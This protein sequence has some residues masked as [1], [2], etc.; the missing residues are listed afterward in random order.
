MHFSNAHC[1]AFC[2]LL[3]KTK[4]FILNLKPS[5]ELRISKQFLD[6]FHQML[7]DIIFLKTVFF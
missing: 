4:T 7:D 2:G 5:A 3:R 6:N 1:G